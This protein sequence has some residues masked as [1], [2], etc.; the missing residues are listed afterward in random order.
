MTD[1][2]FNFFLFYINST[3][4]LNMGRHQMNEGRKNFKTFET[5]SLMS[6]I[7]IFNFLCSNAPRQVQPIMKY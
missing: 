2:H 6:L 7:P 1:V 4:K 3:Y 5:I